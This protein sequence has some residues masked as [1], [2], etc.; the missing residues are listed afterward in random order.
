MDHFRLITK[1]HS[2]SKRAALAD[3]NVIDPRLPSY[4]PLIL[5]VQIVRAKLEAKIRLRMLSSYSK[6]LFQII[7][8]ELQ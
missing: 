4:F 2:Y 3:D 5:L 7:P 6:L 1:G 8:T